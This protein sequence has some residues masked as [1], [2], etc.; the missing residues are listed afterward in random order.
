LHLSITNVD[1]FEDS[2]V[3]ALKL[4]FY[5]F[6]KV[7]NTIEMY[8]EEKDTLENFSKDYYINAYIGSNFILS[9]QGGQIILEYVNKEIE[10]NSIWLF[11]KGTGVNKIDTLEIKNTLLCKEFSDQKNMVIISFGNLVKG[12]EFSPSDTKKTVNLALY[13][14]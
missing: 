11:F 9:F 1:I 14:Q 3:V 10:G 7:I 13:K 2:I 5:D 8:S 4:D 12:F 6:S